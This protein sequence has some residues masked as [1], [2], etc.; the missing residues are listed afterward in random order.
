MLALLTPK[1]GSACDGKRN[2]WKMSEQACGCSGT[3]RSAAGGL[4]AA[5]SISI[6]RA[7]LQL[8]NLLLNR[9]VDEG[10]LSSLIP[11]GVSNVEDV[12]AR[13]KRRP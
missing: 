1:H 2:W 10:K 4:G 8:T 13:H 12:I 6:C 7:K 5:S 11:L 3:V 9:Q